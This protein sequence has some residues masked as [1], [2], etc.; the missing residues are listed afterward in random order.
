MWNAEVDDQLRT[1]VTSAVTIAKQQQVVG[2]LGLTADQAQRLLR[3]PAL[4]SRSLEPASKERDARVALAVIGLALLFTAI[5]FYGGFV[6]VGAIEEKSSRVVEVLLSRLRPTELLTGK[7]VGIGLVGL[8]QFTLVAGSA[9]VALKLSGNTLAPTTTPSTIGWI[10]FWFILA[11]AFYAVLYAAAGSLVSRQEEAQS[12][13]VPIT[14][15]LLVGYIFALQAAQSPDG[16]AAVIGSLFPP[17][18]PMVMT[19][20]MARGWGPGVADPPVGGAHGRHDLRD[21]AAGRT[22][23]LGLGAPDRPADTVARGLA[24]PRGVTCAGRFSPAAAPAS[25]R[26]CRP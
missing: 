6:L 2:E 9:L 21:G 10:V 3:P 23:L 4:P 11:Y 7:I 15:V 26:R 19:V 18:A 5:A 24:R 12:I 20:R 16:V 8:A 1:I 14:A 13:Q 25:A 17:T 22:D